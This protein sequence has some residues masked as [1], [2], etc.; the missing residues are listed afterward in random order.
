MCEFETLFYCSRLTIL[1]KYVS[2]KTTYC[3]TLRYCI[4]FSY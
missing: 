3:Y 1:I 4:L 2:V